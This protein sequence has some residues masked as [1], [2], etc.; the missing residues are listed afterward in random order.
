MSAANKDQGNTKSLESWRF[1]VE[2]MLV[3]IE[4]GGDVLNCI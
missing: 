3:G 1:S 4:S 2:K